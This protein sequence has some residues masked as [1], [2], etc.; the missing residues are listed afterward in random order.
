MLLYTVLCRPGEEEAEG[1]KREVTEEQR[2]MKNS[3]A[4]CEPVGIVEAAVNGDHQEDSM[5]QPPEE[6]E[7]EEEE[8]EE[9]CKFVPTRHTYSFL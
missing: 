2:E 6:E 3:L 4:G 7:G 8:E 5:P 1:K 9:G